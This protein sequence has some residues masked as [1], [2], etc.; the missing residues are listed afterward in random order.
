MANQ[1]LYDFN[2]LVGLM[3]AESLGRLLVGSM[4]SCWIFI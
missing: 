3:L 4:K 1:S 2:K